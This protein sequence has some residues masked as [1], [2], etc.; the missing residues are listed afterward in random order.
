M[1]SES[2]GSPSRRWLWLTLGVLV[3]LAVG[4]AVGWSV[5]TVLSP[6]EDA[7]ASSPYTYVAVKPGEVGASVNLN[8]VATW[9]QVPVG[10]NRA[11]GVVT[12]VSVAAGDEVAQGASV[13]SVNLRPVVVAE[14]A[15][16]AFRAIARGTEGADVAQLQQMLVALGFYSGAVDGKAGAAT[17]GAIMRWQ[18]STAVPQTGIVEIGDVIFVPTLPSRVALDEK[19]V[20]RG[21]TLSGGE[22]VLQGLAAAPTFTMPVTDAQAALIP[23]GAR[24]EITSPS[25]EPWVAFAGAQSSDPDTA[26]VTVTLEAEEGAV[27]CNDACGEIPAVGEEL[28]SSR[29][30]TV[31]TVK[32]LVVPS[33]ALISDAGG[34]IA[35]ITESGERVPVTVLAAARGMSVIEGVE[36]GTNVRIPGEGSSDVAG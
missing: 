31:E 20:Y 28:L 4:V 15:V 11:T 22:A 7:V 34:Q 14:G 24:V 27:I 32:G 26:T 6:A 23:A 9:P 2:A 17:V 18:K 16:P 21:A 3:T 29:V 12:G 33:A 10:A 36:A 35:V 1:T 8:T 30:I 5:S 25:G 13:Y 19:I